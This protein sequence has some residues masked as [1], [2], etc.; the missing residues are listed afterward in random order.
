MGVCMLGLVAALCMLSSS[1]LAVTTLVSQVEWNGASFSLNVNATP[2]FQ[3]SVVRLAAHHGRRAAH[4]MT[5]CSLYQR[6]SHPSL[7]ACAVL[8]ASSVVFAV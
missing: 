1:V 8:M 6:F 2:G 4:G 5:G 3:G 7:D